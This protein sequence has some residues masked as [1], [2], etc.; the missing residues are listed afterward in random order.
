MNSKLYR[1][2]DANI[3]RAC[4]G[5]RVIE[6]VFR[7]YYDKEDITKSSKRLR[8]TLRKNLSKL[9]DKLVL[10]RDS[11]SDVG[12][13]ISQSREI[14]DNKTNLK[15]LVVSN[16]KRVQEALRVIEEN[17]KPVNEY[18][19][20]KEVEK[21]RFESYTL[22]KLSQSI[23]DNKLPEGIYCIVTEKYSNGKTN[24]EVAKEIVKTDVK[25]I[26]Y[27]EKNTDTSFKKM[28]EECKELRKITRDNG[29]KFI[30]N[31]HIELAM[32]VDADGVHIGQDDYPPSEVRKIIGYDKMLGL[33][34]HSPEQAEKSLTYDI[35][36]IGVGPIYKTNT[37]VNVCDPVG[38]E[39]LEYV[40]KNINKDFVAIGGI[41]EHN[42]KE[43][44]SRGAKTICLVTEIIGSDNIQNKINNLYRII[45]ESTLKSMKM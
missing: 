35:D 40:V 44:T 16:F 37:K 41:K 17:L 4:E 19:L 2:I 32:M 22:E 5:F 34:T 1:I 14:D 12:S 25:I 42:I 21:I 15:Q 13:G 9:D 23:Y 33:S 38:Y 3:N 8:H 7:F 11:A 36:Y 27:R 45:N 10:F 39:Y 30:I 31:D 18:E 29:V 28:Y 26:Q 6:D 43:I 20:S 24:I